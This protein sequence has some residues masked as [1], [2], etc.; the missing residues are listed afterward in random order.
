MSE[1]MRVDRGERFRGVRVALGAFRGCWWY[2][3]GVGG[4]LWSVWVC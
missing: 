1:E 3:A 4:V 2:V